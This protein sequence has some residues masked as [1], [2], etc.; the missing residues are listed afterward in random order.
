MLTAT[1]KQLIIFESHDDSNRCTPCRGKSHTHATYAS[2]AGP[3]KPLV[4]FLRTVPVRGNL[5]R[6]PN[7]VGQIHCSREK[8]LP[9]PPLGPVEWPAGSTSVSLPNT[10]IE[11]VCLSQT[12]VDEQAIRL[13]RPISPAYDQYIQYLLTGA[14]PL[15]LNWLRQG[16]QSWRCRLSISHSP[17]FPT[18]GPPLLI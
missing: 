18:D 6:W 13:T 15:V 1:N 4:H 8:V 17:T 11:A 9:T 7:R 3:H 16:L 12:S 2:C 10:T 14:N 5:S